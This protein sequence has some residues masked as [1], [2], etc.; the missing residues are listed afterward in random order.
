MEG[1]INIKVARIEG[2]SQTLLE[3]VLG[4]LESEI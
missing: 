3:W 4:Y 1:L 2:L